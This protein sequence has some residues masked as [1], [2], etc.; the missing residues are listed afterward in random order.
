MAPIIP[1]CIRCRRGPVRLGE[2]RRL[3]VPGGWRSPIERLADASDG[4]R[5]LDRGP[6]LP[7]PPFAP[8]P[9]DARWQSAALPSTMVAHHRPRRRRAH[10]ALEIPPLCSRPSADAAGAARPAQPPAGRCA[11]VDQARRL[12]GPRSRR[13]QDAQGRVP[14]RRGAGGGRQLRGDRRRPAIQ[15]RAPDRGRRGQGR[16]QMPPGAEPQR[17]DL[18][19][20][21]SRERQHAAGP[22]AG[23]HGASH[24][25]SR[26]PRRRGGAPGADTA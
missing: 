11:A 26:D 22:R 6:S 5:F 24:Q 17:A 8:D 15:P 14:D 19:G 16:A 4:S 12:H 21:L 25:L 3:I 18:D 10:A 20:A 13:Q 23:R 2:A 1:D 7:A 9:G